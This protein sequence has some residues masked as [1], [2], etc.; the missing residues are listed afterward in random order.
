MQT[1]T[2]DD[3]TEAVNIKKKASDLVG[4]FVELVK[5]SGTIFS[6]HIH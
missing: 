4:D 3:F 6:G 2:N 1:A 5:R